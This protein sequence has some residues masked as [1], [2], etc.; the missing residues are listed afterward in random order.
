[1]N[2]VNRMILTSCM[3]RKWLRICS[4]SCSLTN[5]TT[6]RTRICHNIWWFL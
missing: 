5:A 2:L 6:C 4:I 1:L 3:L